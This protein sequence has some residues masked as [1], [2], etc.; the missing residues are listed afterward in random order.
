MVEPGAGAKAHRMKNGGYEQGWT[1]QNRSLSWL[2]SP[3][4]APMPCTA[5]SSSFHD[6]TEKFSKFS[7]K[8]Q[9]DLKKIE[10]EKTL[11]R[12]QKTLTLQQLLTL[13]FTVAS[14]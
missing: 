13:L 5:G 1:L 4:G 2:R 7:E 3:Y 11:I 10:S 8:N 12:A 14:D 6:F 9:D